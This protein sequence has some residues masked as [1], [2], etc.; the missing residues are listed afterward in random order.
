MPDDGAHHPVY[1]CVD[2]NLD[3]SSDTG[4]PVDDKDYQ[5]PFAFTGKIARVTIEL[6]QMKKAADDEAEKLHREAT[7][8]RGLSD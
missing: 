6:E 7:L 4:T 8:K 2:E 3:I 5:V 1:P